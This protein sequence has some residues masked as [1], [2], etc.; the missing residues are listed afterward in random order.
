MA[1]FQGDV[2]I[3]TAIELAIEDIKKDPWLIDDIFSDFINNPILKYKYGQKEINR[4]KEW[5]LNNK[6]NFYMKYRVDNMDFPA[7]SISMG[8]SNE[9]KS[10]ATLADQ[11]VCVEELDP[12]EINKPIAY[13]VKPF[14]VVSY[15]KNTGIV[16]APEGTVGLEFV[17]KDMVAV[18]P[19]TGN[20][21]IINEKAG[22]NGF[23]IAAG[24][25]LDVSQLAIVPKYQI[26]RARR[27]RIISQESYNIGCHAHGD[28]STLIFLFALTKYAL[29]RY[30]EGLLE[31][32]NF[33]LGTLQ[34]TD[35]IKNEAFGSD[36]VYSRF[37]TLSGQVEEDWL[38]SPFRVWEAVDIIDREEGMDPGI[39]IKVCANEDIIE[40]SDEAENDLW[41]TIKVDND[42]E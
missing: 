5:V 33:Q 29:L 16:E 42:E 12:C 23:S 9:D 3:K 24:S 11:S 17:S 37:I 19:E 21:F 10:L 22:D 35:M 14:N 40:G 41:T 7:I 27:E 34:C 4:A 6:I 39:G 13:I 32:N 1:L 30:R 2:I 20:G 38:K 18:D 28:P 8:N 31:S 26:Y 15:D 36:N 25:D